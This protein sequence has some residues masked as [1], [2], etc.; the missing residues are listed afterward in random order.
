MSFR[1]VVVRCGLVVGL[2]ST[3][4]APLAFASTPAGAVAATSTT[5]TA[6]ASW[7]GTNP[8]SPNVSLQITEQ[9]GPTTSNLFFL[10]N[11]NFCDTETNTA[12]F[13]SYSANG[14]ERNRVFAVTHDLGEAVLAAPKLTVNFTEQ[15]APECNTNGSDITTVVS[16]PRNVSLFGL[17][18]ATGPAT[19][20]FPG[21]VVRPANATLSAS[22]PA[23]LTLANLGAPAFA[24]ISQYT[25]P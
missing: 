8:G 1:P 16:G 23:P 19:L 11:E 18:H 21:N 6:V 17:W 14:T 2:L 15:T 7:V 12:V 3:V 25:A 5:R 22:A 13:L 10:V 20:T 9:A 4:A 24:Q